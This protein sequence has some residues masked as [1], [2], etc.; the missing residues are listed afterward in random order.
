MTLPNNPTAEL[1]LVRAICQDRAN[2][3]AALAL[4]AGPGIF[5]PD[6]PH[7]AQ[8]TSIAALYERSIDPMPELLPGFDAGLFGGEPTTPQQTAELV[9]VVL[10]TALRRDEVLIAN[11]LG[12][13]ARRESVGVTLPWLRDKITGIEGRYTA[14]AHPMIG[15]PA[16]TLR[17]MGTWSA[18]TGVSAIDQ[19]WRPFSGD[20][21]TIAAPPGGGKT[22]ICIAIAG[23]TSL[24]G[25]P[26]TVI[27]GETPALEIQLG[28]LSQ[29]KDPLL[30]ANFANDIRYNPEFR[31]KTANIDRVE[32]A[33]DKS[34]A[35]VPLRI[36]Q[37]SSGPD[38]V[39]SI[40]ASLTEPNIVLTDHLFAII[41]QISGG[42]EPDHKLFY[43]MLLEAQRECQRG[44]HIH[45]PFNQYT[46][47]AIE[48]Y[49]KRNEPL[50]ETS[51]QGGAGIIAVNATMWHL[52]KPRSALT[53]TPD[54]HQLL[55]GNVVKC[56]ARLV[57]DESG[58]RVDPFASQQ[59][60]YINDRYRSVQLR[61]DDEPI[62]YTPLG[63]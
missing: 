17:Q 36:Y 1:A 44:H 63:F 22:T 12:Q 28:L 14:A 26:T 5:A 20:N 2:F 18:T 42:K 50:D 47:S 25:I 57:C 11:E 43:R 29:L 55:L 61:P 8:W 27:T 30:D 33:W 49:L 56:R 37:V 6:G 24:N 32:S 16:D 45:I 34:F 62:R 60:F 13:R 23:G 59:K 7:G 31:K 4:G 3:Q 40:I 53:S 38:E 48:G 19:V 39:I 21:H 58:N 51:Q 10:G 9:R 52:G 54:G 41:S 35:H 15:N 46:K